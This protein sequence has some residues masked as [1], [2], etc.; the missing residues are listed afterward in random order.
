MEKRGGER[1]KGRERERGQAEHEAVR[2][3]E[4]LGLPSFSSKDF[5]EVPSFVELLYKEYSTLLG[6]MVVTVRS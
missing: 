6:G 1:V 5:R 4:K 3:V 2:D